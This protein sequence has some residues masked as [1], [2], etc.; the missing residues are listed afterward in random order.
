MTLEVSRKLQY[1]DRTA[2]QQADQ[3]IK[4]DIVRALI[5]LVTN[6]D[7]SYRRLE[8]HRMR[9]DEDSFGLVR[10]SV[11]R[12]HTNSTVCV[13]DWA[14]GFSPERMDK[15]VGTYAEETSGIM[16]G[17]EVRGYFGRGLKEAIL[18]LGKGTVS[19]LCDGKFTRGS[20]GVEGYVPKYKRDRAIPGTRALRKQLNI[21][22]GN[23]SSVQL[24]ITRSGVRIPQINNLRTQLERHYALREVLSDARRRVILVE[25]DSRGG[26]RK[27]FSLEYRFPPGEEILVRT[28]SVPGYPGASFTINAFRSDEPLEGPALNK[29]AADG[30]FILRSPRAVLDL[31]LFRFEHDAAAERLF[32]RISCSYL[33]ELLRRGEPIVKADRT[34][35]DWSHPFAKALKRTIE[36]ELAPLV[37][38][39]RERARQ[40]EQGAENKELKNKINTALTALNKIAQSELGKFGGPD[41]A[42]KVPFVPE[43]GFGFVPEYVHV[44][45]GKQAL[46]LLRAKNQFSFRAG[47]VVQVESDNDMVI[48]HSEQ[49][50]LQEDPRSSEVLSGQVII[51]GRQ[52]GAEA[53]L[54]ATCNE[55]KAEGFVKVISKRITVPQPSPK[56]KSGLFDDI[57][58]DEDADPRHRVR[59]NNRT[60]IVSLSA[61]SVSPYIR[62]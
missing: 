25:L 55:T 52:V 22:S 6:V 35:I 42:G 56:K 41:I 1:A 11:C 26:A 36:T 38:R 34:G 60:I 51:E 49:V 31:S 2:L 23:G 20:L 40:R 61:P 50:V 33:D 13:A 8:Q 29:E 12:R 28:V 57:R 30:G 4:K 27:E 21:L 9:Q 39:E 44:V 15:C 14:E 32:G 19:S 3:T 43:S 47:M 54:T 10:I 7:D 16:E 18:G 5:E 62:P 48:V 45:A 17:L 58:F 37:E 59:M 24:T 46:V 53:I